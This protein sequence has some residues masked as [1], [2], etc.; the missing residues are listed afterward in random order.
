MLIERDFRLLSPLLSAKRS[1]EGDARVFVH[2]KTPKGEAE[3]L[4]YLNTPMQRWNWAF[5]EARDALGLDDVATSAI[6]PSH[7]YAVKRTSSYNRKFR[8]GENGPMVTVKHESIPS[9]QGS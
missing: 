9:G 5:L 7:W 6:I 3:E 8:R 1:G 4:V 2:L